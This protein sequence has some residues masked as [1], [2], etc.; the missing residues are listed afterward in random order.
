MNI[1]HANLFPDPGGASKYCNDWLAR[2]IEEERR[3]AAEAK[4]IEDAADRALAEPDP[5][6]QTVE[7]VSAEAVAKLLRNTVRND[8]E[9][10][11]EMLAGWASKL[12]SLYE[13]TAETDWP[14]RTSS[15]LRLKLEFRKFL[16]SNSIN[17][18]VAE[19][20]ARRLIDFFKA[21]WQATHAS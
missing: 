6:P 8:S 16:M 5:T 17:R 3:D 20:G 10:P 15:E 7:A 18:A 1:H 11:P 14:T 9:Y 13:R 4:A 19:T 12:I 2:L 21:N